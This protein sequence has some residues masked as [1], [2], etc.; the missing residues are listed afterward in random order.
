[1]PTQHWLG[2]WTAPRRCWA[3]VKRP[4]RGLRA[5]LGNWR[6][7]RIL[8]SLSPAKKEATASLSSGP[9]KNQDSKT[10]FEASPGHRSNLFV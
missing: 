8:A 1:M 6:C 10:R 5:A 2:A 3:T 9:K 4:L 7:S